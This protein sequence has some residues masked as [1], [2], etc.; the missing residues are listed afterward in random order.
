MDWRQGVT[1]LF[2]GLFP[3]GQDKP[4]VHKCLCLEV[5][6]DVVV[7]PSNAEQDTFAERIHAVECPLDVP[8]QQATIWKML[9]QQCVFS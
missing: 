4:A 9:Q 2:H 8:A 6:R 1:W 7:E 3:V 5:S